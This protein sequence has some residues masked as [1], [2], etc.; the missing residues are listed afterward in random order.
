MLQTARIIHNSPR[1]GRKRVSLSL[2]SEDSLSDDIIEI[3]SSLFRSFLSA[4]A[5]IGGD[6]HSVLSSPTAATIQ[7]NSITF[8][9]CC[10]FQ[11]R[12]RYRE[13]VTKYNEVI[14]EKLERNL[15]LARNAIDS[16]RLCWTSWLQTWPT[17]F[18]IMSSR[19][20]PRALPGNRSMAPF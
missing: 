9:W 16:L 19:K 15:F 5:I 14:V 6:F 18:P 10:I 13:N 2:R 20:K 3:S 8:N 7:F 17:W 1:A 12:E 4:R 11:E